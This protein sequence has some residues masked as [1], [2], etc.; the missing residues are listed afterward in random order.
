MP[1][2]DSFEDSP[3]DNGEAATWTGVDEAAT[4]LGLSKDAVRKRI[5]RGS[6]ES[7]RGNDGSVRV[8]VAPTT[9]LGPVL[10]TAGHGADASGTTA[11]L[12]ENARLAERLAA[13]ERRSADLSASLELE[14]ARADAALAAERSR[15][16]R[17]AAELAL[18]RRGWLLRV[19]ETVRRR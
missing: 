11:L 15:A 8:L 12:V 16:D 10:D 14:R 4:R 3:T 6:L 7:R 9:R 17:L 19:L 5:R 1:V 2:Q 13:E 18:A